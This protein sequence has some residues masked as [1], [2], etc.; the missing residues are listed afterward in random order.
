MLERIEMDME[1][2]THANEKICLQSESWLEG[3]KQY[4]RRDCLMF[5]GLVEETEEKT[6]LKV[7]ETAA[8]MRL[9]IS[10]NEVSISQ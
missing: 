2:G 7:I 5:L 8:A 9:E 4:P 10:V 3:M 1:T 6:T